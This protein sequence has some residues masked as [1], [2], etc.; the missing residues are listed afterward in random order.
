LVRRGAV[1]LDGMTIGVDARADG[2]KTLA[3]LNKVIDDILAEA[4]AVD[5][6]EDSRESNDA[7]ALASL[8]DF[9]HRLERLPEAK[10][11]CR[12]H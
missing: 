5:D 1:A 6:A 3:W 7:S 11:A 9:D 10:G 2:N 8:A 12:F 4:A